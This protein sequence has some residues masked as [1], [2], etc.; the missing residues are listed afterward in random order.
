MKKQ[1]TQPMAEKIEFN[2]KE[3]IV[4]SGGNGM[5]GKNTIQAC[6]KGFISLDDGC[7]PKEG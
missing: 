1:Y 6:W 5:V 7:R 2:Y 4:A 3:T